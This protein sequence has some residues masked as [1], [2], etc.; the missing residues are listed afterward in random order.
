MNGIRRN[1]SIC[2]LFIHYICNRI[3]QRSDEKGYFFIGSTGNLVKT[4]KLKAKSVY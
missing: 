4:R 1:Y 2:T 3:K